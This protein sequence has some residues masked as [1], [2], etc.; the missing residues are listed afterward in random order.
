MTTE[1]RVVSPTHPGHAEDIT[2]TTDPEQAD[3]LLALWRM[4]D[5]GKPSAYLETRTVTDWTRQ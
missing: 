2:V 3:R 4:N 1:Y 5:D